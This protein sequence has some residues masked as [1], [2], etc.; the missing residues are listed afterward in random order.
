MNNIDKLIDEKINLEKQYN[1]KKAEYKVISRRARDFSFHVRD[2]KD[3]KLFD[4][5][6]YVV[7]FVLGYVFGQFFADLIR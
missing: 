2:R 4:K 1:Q 7:S 6:Y 5:L 3:S